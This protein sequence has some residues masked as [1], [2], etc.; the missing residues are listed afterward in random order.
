MEQP[1]ERETRRDDPSP[2]RLVDEQEEAAAPRRPGSVARS[3][4]PTRTRGRPVEE[5]GGGEAEGFEQAE[6]ALVRQASHEDPGTSPTQEVFA[7]EKESDR[8]TGVSGEPDEVDPTE[9]TSDPA[10][11][12]TTRARA[13][14]RRGAL[15]TAPTGLPSALARPGPPGTIPRPAAAIGRV[16]RGE[17]GP[18]Q[19]ALARAGDSHQSPGR[20]EA[21]R[22]GQA[23][24]ARA[25]RAAR[26]WLVQGA[27]HLRPPPH[28]RVRHAEKPALGRRRGHGPRDDRRSPGLH[29]L[30]GL[31][32][33]RWLAG[34]RDVQDHGPGGQDRLPGDRDQRL[35][36]RP[37]LQE[38]V[39][40]LGAYGD[41]F[42]RNVQ[43]SV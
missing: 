5:G 17:A 42:V 7:P 40:S 24:G 4:R 9:V 29:L 11:D 8:A 37:H 16:I 18:A 33:L 23:D 22:Q 3:P 39:V 19:R 43:C 21:A 6:A 35:R 15:G 31:H 36:R 13:R 38:G 20:G 41:V 32:R 12:R 14:N 34:R 27:R 26:P 30:P 1:G 2:D 25:C 10:G 28:R